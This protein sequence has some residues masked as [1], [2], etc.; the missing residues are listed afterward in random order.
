M[1]KDPLEYLRHINDECLYILSVSKEDLSKDDLLSNETLKR[2]IVRSLEIIGEATKN[3]PEEF[4][5]KWNS[6]NWK[7]MAGMRD[8]LIHDYMGINYS[9][10]WDVIINKIP[11]LSQQVIDVIENEQKYR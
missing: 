9:I 7:N 5:T 2:A 8:R 3:I 4:K 11:E 1:S 6:I 10:V